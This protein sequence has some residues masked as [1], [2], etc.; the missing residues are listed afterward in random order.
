MPD[1]YCGRDA[2]EHINYFRHNK[3]SKLS[4]ADNLQDVSSDSNAEM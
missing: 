4:Q 3:S 2:G 1:Q